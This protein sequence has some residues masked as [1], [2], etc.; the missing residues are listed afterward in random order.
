MRKPVGCGDRCV[1]RRSWGPVTAPC[2]P[3]RPRCS[4]GGSKLC[5]L[6]PLDT[7]SST[8]QLLFVQ[9]SHPGWA[10]GA[11]WQQPEVRVS[12]YFGRSALQVSDG[13]W[14][15]FSWN[16][17]FYFYF[18]VAEAALTLQPAVRG[19]MAEGLPERAPKPATVWAELSMGAAGRK[20]GAEKASAWGAGQSMG[21]PAPLGW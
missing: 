4:S 16:L 6:P 10:F 19:S 17:D 13:L 9:T 18:H 5:P 15:D 7:S 21:K 2:G 14:K 3:D 20:M 11:M 8:W 12:F 1:L